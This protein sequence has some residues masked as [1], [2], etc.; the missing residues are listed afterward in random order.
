MGL[1]EKRATCV[2]VDLDCLDLHCG[3]SSEGVEIVF[4]GSW[5]G[6]RGKRHVLKV[7]RGKEYSH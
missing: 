7:K 2:H 6:N 3:L 5:K 4:K 1:A